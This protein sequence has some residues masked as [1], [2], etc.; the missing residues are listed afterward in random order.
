M[1]TNLTLVKKSDNRTVIKMSP[2]R[3][4]FEDYEP[5]YSRLHMSYNIIPNNAKSGEEELVDALK[6]KAIGF[7]DGESLLVRP[8]KDMYAIMCEDEDGKFWFHI[9]KNILDKLTIACSYQEARH[10][11]F[12]QPILTILRNTHIGLDIPNLQEK[13][14]KTKK[15]S[16][17]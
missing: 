7:C 13:M 16:R 8:K 6:E 12:M 15:F 11:S 9:G 14:E 3:F 4:L 2:D 1:N 10:E 17:K 5:D